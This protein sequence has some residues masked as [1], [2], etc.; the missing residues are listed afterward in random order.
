MCQC[1]KSR[2]SGNVCKIQFLCVEMRSVIKHMCLIIMLVGHKN[3]WNTY[4]ILVVK[5]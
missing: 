5:F 2:K 1:L 3:V 4:E